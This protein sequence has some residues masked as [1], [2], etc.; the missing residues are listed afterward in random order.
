MLTTLAGTQI[1]PIR[2]YTN[3]EF[4]DP[5]N[6]SRT[7]RLTVPIDDTSGALRDPA[8]SRPQGHLRRRTRLPRDHPQP[9]WSTTRPGPSTSS[10]TT[11]RSSSSTTTTATATTAVDFGYPVDGR[12][13]RILIESSIPIETAARPRHPGQ[14]H[15]LGRGHLRPARA[16]S[17]TTDPPGPDDGIWRVVRARRQRLGVGHEPPAVHDRARLPLPAR[18]RR[19]TPAS[20]TCPTPA[21][22][23][24]STPPTKL[25]EDR[26]EEV[27]FRT[28]AAGTTP[29]R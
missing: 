23:S 13:M 11:R 2:Q 1:D 5:L 6:D 29:R 15:P 20:T 17:P 19:S 4:S 10:R 26:S 8:P 3:F 14:S 16:R 27:V 7:A 25:G 21:S 9:R 18:R 12:G 22:W 24:S 28:G